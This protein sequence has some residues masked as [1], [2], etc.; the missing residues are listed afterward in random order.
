MIKHKLGWCNRCK[1]HSVAVK[2]NKDKGYRLDYCINKGCGYKS[3]IGY[4]YTIVNSDGVRIVSIYQRND[5]CECGM[6]ID[7]AEKTCL[8][9]NIDCNRG[10]CVRM[11]ISERGQPYE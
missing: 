5:V 4:P 10:H 9:V 2:L 1:E 11:A 7:E 8:Y 3:T 6:T